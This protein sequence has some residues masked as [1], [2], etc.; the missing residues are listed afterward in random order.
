M[1]RTTVCAIALLFAAASPAEANDVTIA[2]SGEGRDVIFIPGLGSSPDVMDEVWAGL[3]EVRVHAVSIAGFAGAAPG[4]G[5]DVLADTSEAIADHVATEGLDCPVV[6]GHSLGVLVAVML[7]AK[8]DIELCGLV[9]I[10]GPPA[11]GAVMVESATPEALA[12]LA[13]NMAGPIAGM[14]DAVFTAWAG[15]MAQGWATTDEARAQVAAMIARSD[16]GRISTAFSQ[17]IQADVTPLLAQIDL[18]SLVLYTTPQVPGMDDATIGGFY[19]FAFSSLEDASLVHIPDAG[20]FVMLDAPEATALA[21][22]N[23]FEGL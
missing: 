6:V 13:D 17:V 12:G 11:P 8:D 9:L 7:A 14:S 19:A 20:H 23:F 2:T 18:P 10:D 21:I 3:G 22:G 16:P 15:G 1:F 5:T 4:A